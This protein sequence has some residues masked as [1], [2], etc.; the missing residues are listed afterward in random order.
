MLSVK[1]NYYLDLGVLNIVNRLSVA[2]NL[3]SGLVTRKSQSHFRGDL[4]NSKK[5]VPW[6]PDLSSGQNSDGDRNPGKIRAEGNGKG[7]RA[8]YLLPVRSE[9][10]SGA[11]TVLGTVA[12]NRTE[13]DRQDPQLH[14]SHLLGVGEGE[15]R[16]ILNKKAMK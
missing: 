8:R 4:E 2:K 7:G 3:I 16:K 1:C 5:Q 12:G 14:S 13:Q 9:S 15:R 6:L 10:A 11:G